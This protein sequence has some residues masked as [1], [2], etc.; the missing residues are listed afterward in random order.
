VAGSAGSG[1]GL[2]LVGRSR[3]AIRLS[4]GDQCADV[5]GGRWS[6]QAAASVAAAVPLM[7]TAAVTV[8]GLAT[9]ARACCV[10]RVNSSIRR[11]VV[12]AAASS[13]LQY[14]N[15]RQHPLQLRLGCGSAL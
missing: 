12:A 11:C 14:Q 10:R 8:D 4:V 9:G 6:T 3:S 13:S 15:T 5:A 2:R 1:R 7:R